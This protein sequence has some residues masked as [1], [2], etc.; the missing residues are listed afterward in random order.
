[1]P[2]LNFILPHWLYW[3]GLLLFPAAAFFIYRKQVKQ[4]TTQDKPVSLALAYCLLLTGGFV[5][6]HRMYLK[7]M[8]AVAFIV[9]F[10]CI[11]A[12]NIQVRD[13]REQVSGVNNETRIA[14]FRIESA[15]KGVDA[16]DADAPEKLAR[17]QSRLAEI[18]DRHAVV[19]QT[20]DRWDTAAMSLGL[21]V[22][23]LM[24]FD[25]WQLP[26]LVGRRNEIE[27]VREEEG[28]RCPAVES[29]YDPEQEPF[30]F[31]RI[32]SRINGM[33]GEMVAYWSVIAVIVYYYEVIARYVFNSPTNWAHESMFLMFGMQYL[34]AG[35]YVLREGAH[36]R[37]DVIY[38]FF[39]TRTKAIIDV[40]TS[41]FFFVFM[42]TLLVTGYIFFN[43]SLQVSEVSF[44][45]WAVQYWPI[46]FAI[47]LGAA[48]LMLQGV[49][50][51]VKDIAV[52]MGNDSV[53]LHTEV[54]PE[55]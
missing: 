30:R 20:S 51:L 5:G 34:L 13:V 38:G 2:E 8:W 17:A 39:S 53:D 50:Q 11:Q 6:V 9:L 25:A 10:I 18:N 43:D 4:K 45:E 54:R 52:L 27:S 29:E 28:F 44:T 12:V 48:L 3:G 55:G 19:S 16:G 49:A 40:I 31:N 26:K 42:A 24:A 41:F 23:L 47:P 7:S 14:E 15:Q 36:V 33:F 32:V 46:K 1:M 37:V 21:V 35:G 22:L